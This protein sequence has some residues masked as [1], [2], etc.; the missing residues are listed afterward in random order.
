MAGGVSGQEFNSLLDAG[1]GPDVEL[2]AADGVEDVFAE[3][4]VFDVR[5]GDEYALRARQ[6]EDTAHVEEALDFFVHAADRLN[7]AF[8]IER[9][10]DG[11]ILTK[12]KLRKRGKQC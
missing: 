8:L 11:N 1:H 3:H 2:A 6:A 12:R 4:Q 7:V 10:G 9:S 5:G